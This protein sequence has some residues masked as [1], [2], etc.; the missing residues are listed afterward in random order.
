MNVIINGS[1]EQ[2]ARDTTLT[3]LIQER[4]LPTRGIA[5]AVNQEVVRS[6]AWAQVALTEGDVIDI[7][8]ARQG[9]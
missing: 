9:G 3:T 1:A 6:A 2:V 7:V 4:Q 5:I 8:T